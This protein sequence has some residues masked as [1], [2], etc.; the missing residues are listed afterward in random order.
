MELSRVND[1]IEL[2]K[3]LQK[4]GYDTLTAIKLAEIELTKEEMGDKT[5]DYRF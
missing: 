5:N 4:E 3:K 2:S 1:L